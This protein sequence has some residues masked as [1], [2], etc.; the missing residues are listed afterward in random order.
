MDRPETSALFLYAERFLTYD[1]GNKHPLQ[2]KRLKMVNDLLRAYGVL[3]P[4]GPI[5][6]AEPRAA[7]EA[8]IAR[9]HR[10]DFIEAVRKAGSGETSDRAY[11]SR[12]GIGP[13]DTPAFP[14]M[15]EAAA[16]Y[17][18]GTIEATEALLSGRYRAAFN[19]AGGLHHAHP[20]RA[21][22]FCT[23]NDLAMGIHRFLEA[24]ME[25]VLY[26]DID[27][28]H[29]DGTQNCFYDDPRVM[30]VSLHESGQYLFPGTGFPEETGGPSAPGTSL[31]VPLFPYT[32]DDVW[33]EAFDA[34]VPLAFERFRPQAVVLQLGA[35][36]HWEDPLAHLLLTSEGWMSAVRKLLDLS[37]GL[38]VTV[39]GGG[40]YNLRTVMRLW[41]M[42]AAA[43]AGIELPNEVPEE[44]AA[45]TGV[46]F[47]HDEQVPD[48]E[49]DVRRKSRD[50]A[51]E[52]VRRLHQ[53]L[54]ID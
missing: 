48:T 11:L 7:T 6:H 40:G 3:A 23:F 9:V 14:G 34:V 4:T 10:D 41:T 51:R 31:N 54:G 39:T 45:R 38:P 50:Y 42:V 29:G 32:M 35:D 15:Y 19:V 20:H 8:E 24:G 1:L 16:L 49:E 43:C 44:I 25:R 28:H 47:L 36:A 18:G 53:A 52:M 2:Q 26:V 37:A 21:S 5:D 46:R 27:A 12:F 33:H 22:G 30:T 13:G 17:S